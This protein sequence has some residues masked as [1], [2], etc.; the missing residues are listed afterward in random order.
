LELGELSGWLLL[1]ALPVLLATCTAFTKTSVV[2]GAV[3][4]GLGAEAL[5]PWGAML[6]LALL[7]TTIVMVPVFVS[8]L[9]VLEEH[10]GVVRAWRLEDI[11]DLWRIL[12]APLA[13]FLVRHAN[14]DEL[15][16]FSEL[17]GF[18]SDHPLAL[19]PAFLVTELAEAFHMAVLVLVPFVAVDLV[20]AQAIA[21]WGITSQPQALVTLPLKLLL[22]LAADGWDVVVVGLVEGYR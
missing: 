2:L 17:Q 4:V 16:F 10:G 19:I 6:A 18:P 21:L 5:L 3:R 22:F 13:G 11:V 1:A 7:V 15:A 14:P 20:V 8:T 12:F 9:M